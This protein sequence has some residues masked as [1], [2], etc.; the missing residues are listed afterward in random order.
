MR[1]LVLQPRNTIGHTAGNVVSPGL[2]L[3]MSPPVSPIAKLGLSFRAGVPIRLALDAISAKHGSV[4]WD[5]PASQNALLQETV[6]YTV[7]ISGFTFGHF[8]CKRFI[9]LIMDEIDHLDHSFMDETLVEIATTYCFSPNKVASNDPCV[10]TVYQV[11]GPDRPESLVLRVSSQS[12]EL[13]R[14]VWPAGLALYSYLLDSST[15][16]Y[17]DVHNRRVLELGAGTGCS[18][19]A[20]VHAG[21]QM[22][23]MTDYSV[24]VV[25][26]MCINVRNNVPHEKDRIECMILN[27][28]NLAAVQSVADG[29]E[30]DTVV[31]ADV[32][33][34]DEL[35]VGMVR[36]MAA[37]I[38]GKRVGYM[39]VTRRGE[40]TQKKLEEHFCSSGLNV[41]KIVEEV[42]ARQLAT[43]FHYLVG[44][45][46]SNVHVYRLFSVA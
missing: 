17:A 4:A 11:P 12:N 29:K 39:I 31:A 3:K 33:Y 25:E 21:V 37:I 8:R 18:A 15:C 20:Y 41:D 9:R 38:V 42:P 14:C 26:N 13:G 22:A 34:D 40:Q 32:T 27:A 16:L 28:W 10:H 24:E 23:I 45:D 5:T 2:Y 7:P 44:W 35:I 36:A 30:I 46:F 19:R 1:I 43:N 6:L